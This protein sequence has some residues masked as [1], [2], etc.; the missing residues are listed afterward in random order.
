MHKVHSHRTARWRSIEKPDLIDRLRLCPYGTRGA[1]VNWQ[2]TLIIASSRLDSPGASDTLP[3]SIIRRAIF[4]LLVHGDDY[5]NAES[6]S[7]LDWLEDT[8]AAK[9]DIKTQRIGEGKAGDGREKLKKGQ[10]LNRAVRLTKD[11]L[12]LEAD[13]CRAEIIVEQLGLN[14]ANEVPTLG[15]GVSTRSALY[16][17]E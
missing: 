6:S 16:D 10:V 4:G 17:E 2:Q 8:L 5:L 3:C 9:Y 11:G 15:A 12:E 14:D 7:C 1:A 13:L